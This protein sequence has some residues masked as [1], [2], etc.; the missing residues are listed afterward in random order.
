MVD[1]GRIYRTADRMGGHSA[2]SVP[3]GTHRDG[4]IDGIFALFGASR[5][6]GLQPAHS[7]AAPGCRRTAGI[8]GAQAERVAARGVGGVSIDSAA[9]LG[10]ANSRTIAGS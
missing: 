9:A 2:E 7:Y 1:R 8:H 5:I 10:R 3:A 4:D 6:V